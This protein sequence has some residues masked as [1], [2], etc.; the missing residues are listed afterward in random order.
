MRVLM[1][2]ELDTQLTNKAI[3]EGR[4]AAIMESVF[5]RIRPEAAHFGAKDGMRTAYV[6]FDLVNASDIPSVAEPFFQELNARIEFIPVMN[7][8]DVR[9]G[10]QNFANAR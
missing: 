10:L 8:D 6:V 7:L 2:V 4:L 5:E 1:T 9:T 3:T